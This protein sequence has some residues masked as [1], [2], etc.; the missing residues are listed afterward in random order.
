MRTLD[1][2]VVFNDS[3]VTLYLGIDT[4]VTLAVGM[5]VKGERMVADRYFNVKIDQA[6]NMFVYMVVGMIIKVAVDVLFTQATAVTRDAA[7]QAARVRE[8]E[9]ENKQQ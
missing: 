3:V 5:L 2:I 6:G 7:I 1:V 9:H 4:T 8:E